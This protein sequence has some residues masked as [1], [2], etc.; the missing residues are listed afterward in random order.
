MSVATSRYR[1][2]VSGWALIEEATMLGAGMVGD[3]AAGADVVEAEMPLQRLEAEICEL[4]G[5]LA[6]E[7]R[8]LVLLSALDPRIEAVFTAPVRPLG[9][10]DVW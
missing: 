9:P 10:P 6:G 5:H 2:E 1:A 3:G 4:A 7:C 8:W